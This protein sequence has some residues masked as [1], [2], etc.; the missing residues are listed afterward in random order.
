MKNAEITI[1]TRYRARISGYFVTVLVLAEAVKRGY[2]SDRKAFLCRNE[3]TNR[4]LVL[5]AAKLRGRAAITQAQALAHNEEIDRN[6][7][8]G[9]LRQ[10]V[11]IGACFDGDLQG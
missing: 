2:R 3:R 5:T 10:P 6:K 8:I 1:G 4:E 7:S 9:N 11:T